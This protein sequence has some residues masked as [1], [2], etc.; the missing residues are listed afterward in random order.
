MDYPLLD[1][2]LLIIKGKLRQ[3]E[4]KKREIKEKNR[5]W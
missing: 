5:P 1:L 4:T 3:I 2:L